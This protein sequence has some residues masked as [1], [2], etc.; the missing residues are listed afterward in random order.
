MNIGFLIITFLMLPLYVFIVLCILWGFSS[1]VHNIKEEEILNEIEHLE[2]KKRL[3]K[4]KE[5]E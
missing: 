2:N 5:E 4:I 3:L 1:I